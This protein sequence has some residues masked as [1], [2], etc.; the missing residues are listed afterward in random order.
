M[1]DPDRV[2][3]LARLFVAALIVAM[4]AVA[5][6][7][8]E[9]WPLTSFRLFSTARIDEQTRWS[10]TTVDA[11]GAERAYPLGGEERGFRGFPF[12][13][14][15][16]VATDDAR[17][18]ELCRTWVEAAPELVGVDAVEVRLYLRTWKVSQ[19]AGDE[20][21]P[22]RIELIYECGEGGVDVAG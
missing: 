9:P 11:E 12:V 8:L 10:A 19:R 17:R 4:T 22:G 15:E 2:P 13:M 3:R 5:V 14:S 21:L 18:D 16:F 7:A 20:A 6:F 1:P